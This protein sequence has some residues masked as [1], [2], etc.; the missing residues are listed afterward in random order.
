MK[1]GGRKPPFL[2]AQGDERESPQEIARQT[3]TVIF[4]EP[5]IPYTRTGQINKP[6]SKII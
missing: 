3:D 1:K 5:L 6:P 2:F 4:Y